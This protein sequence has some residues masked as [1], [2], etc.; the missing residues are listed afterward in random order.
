MDP[1]ESIQE[2]ARELEKLKI[3][4]ERTGKIISNLENKISQLEDLSQPIEERSFTLEESRYL[5]GSRV[6][7]VNPSKREPNVGHIVSVGKLYIKVDLGS[8]LTRNR[9]AKN[10]RLIQEP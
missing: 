3:S 4:H 6:R 10:L 2:I 9:I 1:R 5:I 8:G 7:I